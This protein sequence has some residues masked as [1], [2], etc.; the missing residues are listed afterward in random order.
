[1]DAATI[2]E[3]LWEGRLTTVPLGFCSVIALALTLERM[4]RFRGLDRGAREL[5]RQVVAAIVRRDYGEARRLSESSGNPIGPIFLEGLRW[6]NITLADLERVLY[7]SREESVRG[8]RRGLWVIAS[9]GSLAVFVGL[10]GTVWGIMRAFHDLAVTGQGGFE[11]V[12][13]GISEALIATAVGLIVAISAV[14]FYNYLQTRVSGIASTYAR[15]CERFVQALLYVEA[16]AEAPETR[17]AEV[18]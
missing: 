10:F 6:R 18:H 12:A 15:A 3:F 14:F 17:H 16:S 11:V 2:L 1:V 9:I 13:S 5:T 8:L 7:T 4:W